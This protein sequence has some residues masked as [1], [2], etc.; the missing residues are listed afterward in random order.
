MEHKCTNVWHKGDLCA[1]SNNVQ[2]GVFQV[3]AI[4]IFIENKSMAS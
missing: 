3:K 4:E 1:S 2:Q